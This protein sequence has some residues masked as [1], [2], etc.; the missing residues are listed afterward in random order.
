M[1]DPERTLIWFKGKRHIRVALSIAYLDTH[2][3]DCTVTARN[4]KGN[5]CRV[6]VWWFN[7]V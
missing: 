5:L 3:L 7:Y 1:C 4:H 2:L 6:E